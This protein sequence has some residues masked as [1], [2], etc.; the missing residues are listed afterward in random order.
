MH[1]QVECRGVYNVTPLLTNMR[2]LAPPK[3]DIPS[4]LV[5][6][7]IEFEYAE[8]YIIIEC[9]HGRKL[10]IRHHYHPDVGGG[11]HRSVLGFVTACLCVGV[12]LT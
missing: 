1:T 11:G 4:I 5:I 2:D 12:R 3:L 6:Q 7:S 10:L 9:V 8:K